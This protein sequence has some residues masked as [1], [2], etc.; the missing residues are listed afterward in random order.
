M[1]VVWKRNHG[2]LFNTTGHCSGVNLVVG[3]EQQN[4]LVASSVIR[5]G[6]KILVAVTA[7]VKGPTYIIVR[8]CKLLDPREFST[9]FG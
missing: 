6:S 1:S 4:P 5:D 3:F 2:E 9:V 7:S 8:K